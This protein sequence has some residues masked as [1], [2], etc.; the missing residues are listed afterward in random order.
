MY[1]F[2][3]VQTAAHIRWQ[4]CFLSLSHSLTQ[5]SVCAFAVLCRAHTDALHS[6]T[7]RNR[8]LMERAIFFGGRTHNRLYLNSWIKIDAQDENIFSS[9]WNIVHF[10]SREHFVASASNSQIVARMRVNIQKF[11][12]E[13]KALSVF[14]V[15]LFIVR[16]VKFRVIETVEN[17]GVASISAMS[18]EL[19]V[20]FLFFLSVHLFS[21]AFHKIRSIS[22]ATSS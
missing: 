1:T 13:E 11:E 2:I 20:E 16:Q 17:K 15:N 10:T 4:K 22:L 14:T 8:H 7:Q 19:C 21:I 3:V 9:L 5:H 12:Q 6:S 18:F